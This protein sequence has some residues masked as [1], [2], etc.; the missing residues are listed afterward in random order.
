MILTTKEL[1]GYKL[2]ASDGGIGHVKDFYFDDSTW[3][4]RY[5]VADTGTWL[6][7]RQVLLPPHAFGRFDHAGKAL[8]VNLTRQQIE[9]SPP[10]ESHQPVSRQYETDYYQYYG[11][12]AYW[13]GG[14]LL[15]LAAYPVIVQPTE[16]EREAE[17]RRH[18]QDDPNLR[19][20]R[21]VT[22]YHL[23]AVDGPIGHLCGLTVDDRSW[24]I[25]DLVVEAG[26]W[27]AGKEILI[28]PAKAERIS[29]EKSK[30]FLNLTQADIRQTEENNPV[31]ADL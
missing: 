2:A 13:N 16:E 9:N 27:Y 15:G 21:A 6:R 5:L 18:D 31:P 22:G 29:Q 12:P 11:W 7:G 10:I 17:E 25:R 30:I 28:S 3:A 24:T 4:V 14:S 26:P 8:S 23:Q 20:A 19:S 1:Y